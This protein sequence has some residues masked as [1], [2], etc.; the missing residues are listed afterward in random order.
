MATKAPI[1]STQVA[2]KAAA[3]RT[4][5]KPALLAGG[6]PQIAPQ[7]ATAGGDAPAQATIAAM[8][9][10]QR[11]V[12]RRLDARIVRT[13]PRVTHVLAGVRSIAKFAHRLP[14]GRANVAIG[15]PAC[16]S[17][18]GWVSAKRVTQHGLALAGVG[19]RPSA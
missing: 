17:I 9:G 10:W 11:D 1:E 8:P 3:R 4:A 7:I 12:G 13:V 19:L 2:R 15:T 16:A 5:A 6:N 14:Q 18:V